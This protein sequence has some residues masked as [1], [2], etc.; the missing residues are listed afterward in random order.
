MINISIFYINLVK[1][2]ILKHD[3]IL[4]LYHFLTRKE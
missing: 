1:F 2:G 3:T 4:K